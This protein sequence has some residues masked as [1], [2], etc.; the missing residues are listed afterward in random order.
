MLTV[1]VGAVPV[2]MPA[3]VGWGEGLLGG[4]EGLGLASVSVGLGMG[5]VGEVD[6]GC[7]GSAGAC[8]SP[9]PEPEPELAGE[10]PP[11]GTT[12]QSPP[13]VSDGICS[14]KVLDMETSGVDCSCA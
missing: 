14:F 3:P 2:A 11:E 6:L 1:D 12:T 10:M 9:V 13:G 7:C 8:A 4:A 5:G